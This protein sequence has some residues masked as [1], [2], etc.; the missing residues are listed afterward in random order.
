MLRVLRMLRAVADYAKYLQERLAGRLS[1]AAA[2][3]CGALEHLYFWQ[4]C[5]TAFV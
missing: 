2:P 1:V 4:D 3:T 5:R